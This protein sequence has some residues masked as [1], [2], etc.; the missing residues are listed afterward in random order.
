MNFKHFITLIILIFTHSEAVFAQYLFDNSSS[1]AIG[2]RDPARHASTEIDAIINNPAGVAFLSYGFNVS[3]SSSFSMYKDYEY[4]SIT[5]SSITTPRNGVYT[6]NVGYLPSIQF[7][8]RAE[9]WALCASVAS[10][11]GR[12]DGRCD[13]GTNSA[14]NLMQFP[15][16][17]IYNEEFQNIGNAALYAKVLLFSISEDGYDSNKISIIPVPCNQKS[18]LGDFTGRIGGTYRV[19]LQ[20]VNLAFYLGLRMSNIVSDT[21]SMVKLQV[22]DDNVKEYYDVRDYFSA[23]QESMEDES[24][25]LLCEQL[26]NSTPYIELKVWKNNQINQSFWY[27]MPVIGAHLQYQR[28]DI[29]LHY[30]IGSFEQK[31]KRLPGRLSAGVSY[32]ILPNLTGALS[33][34]YLN[35]DASFFDNPYLDNAFNKNNAITYRTSSSL[36]YSFK[37]F[38]ISGGFALENE[39]LYY[40][41]GLYY[42]NAGPISNMSTSIGLAWKITNQIRF[43]MGYNIQSHSLDNSIGIDILSSGSKYSSPQHT[44]AFG[45]KFNIFKYN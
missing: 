37:Q 11:S 40:N 35:N 20:K 24:N 21:R 2:V 30:E 17:S 36:T 8:Y 43:D 7:A 28:L 29:G 45:V 31:G 9:K 10:E 19:N 32:L 16:F 12:W 13:E 33:F 15:S 26:A 44:F 3:L 42:R 25:R 39:P 5:N 18:F 41:S 22:Y 4:R 14:F 27:V 6:K 34:S 1:T 38:V 23:L